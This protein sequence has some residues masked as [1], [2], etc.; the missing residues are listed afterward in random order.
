MNMPQPVPSIVSL[1]RKLYRTVAN[2]H[3]KLGTAILPAKHLRLGGK[4][5]K[6]DEFFF[7]SA[8]AEA[9]R[10]KQACG[11]KPGGRVLDVGCGVGRLAIGLLAEFGDTVSYVGVDVDEASVNW[12]RSHIQRPHPYFTFQRINVRNRRYN[13]KGN[14]LEKG[15]RFPFDDN[16]FDIVSLYSVFSHMM[17]DDIRVYLS[18]FSRLLVPAGSIFLT[19][20]VEEGVPEASENPVGYRMQWRGDLHCVRFERT[21]FEALLAAHGFGIARFEHGGETDGQSALYLSR[22][23][24][25]AHEPRASQRG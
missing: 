23:G 19:A 12:C 1:T 10:L 24:V 3:V 7:A 21:Y 9:R 6:S 15:F 25:A 13:P 2:D 4:E 18:E 20:F 11:L 16:G 5:F 22:V 8:R 14:L 17:S